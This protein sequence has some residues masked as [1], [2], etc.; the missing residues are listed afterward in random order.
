[1]TNAGKIQMPQDVDWFTVPRRVRLRST[2]TG[3]NGICTTARVSEW[4]S[5]SPA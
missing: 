1:M 4:W 5:V 3:D 2:S